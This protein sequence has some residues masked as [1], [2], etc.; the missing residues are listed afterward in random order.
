MNQKA[1]AVA[2][3][4]GAASTA[5]GGGFFTIQGRGSHG[6]MPQ[7]GIDSVVVAS[8]V[9]MALQ[10]V[11]SHSM[12]PDRFAVVTVGSLKAGE[13]P[14]VIADSARL[15]LRCGPRRPMTGRR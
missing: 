3:A 6:S 9:V 4:R 2:I 11:V 5:V 13:A 8:E 7:H 14:N 1:G 10:T 12:A 15:G